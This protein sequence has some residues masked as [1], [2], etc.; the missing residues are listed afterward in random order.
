MVPVALVVAGAVGTSR[1]SRDQPG[2][3]GPGSPQCQGGQSL[4]RQSCQ[5]AKPCSGAVPGVRTGHWGVPRGG[6]ELFWKIP[7]KTRKKKTKKEKL[8]DSVTLLRIPGRSCHVLSAAWGGVGR[9]S[10][11]G[12]RCAA[13]ARQR[14]PEPPGSLAP[15]QS[16]PA[17]TFLGGSNYFVAFKNS[18]V[19]TFF[20]D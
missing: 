10:A 7:L 8:L 19:T 14:P 4:A 3:R 1:G 16:P 18:T 9:E 5:A 20:Y 6:G 11:E 13:G 2:Q 12:L 15:A 17:T